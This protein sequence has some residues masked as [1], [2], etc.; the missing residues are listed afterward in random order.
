MLRAIT[1]TAYR[2]PAYTREVLAALAQ[3]DGIAAWLL[4]PN[5]EPGHEEVI[6]AFRQWSACESRLTVNKERL[7]LNRNTQKALVRALLLRAEV[8]VHLEDDT[9]P[10]P[11]ALQY[12]DWA[13]RETLIPDVKSKDGHQIT[14]ASGYNKPKS[15]P[16]PRSSKN[17]NGSARK[18][19]RKCCEIMACRNRSSA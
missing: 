10:S 14:L 18:A 1:M 19:S 4:L 12:F 15:Q 11:D 6:A 8:V 17:S 7:G 5:V 3:C 2:R 13:V 9:V 16:S